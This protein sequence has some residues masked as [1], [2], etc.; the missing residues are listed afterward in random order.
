MRETEL[1][2]FEGDEGGEENPP[3]ESLPEEPPESLLDGF[4]PPITER[5]PI[6]PEHSTCDIQTGDLLVIYVGDDA[7][8]YYGFL[9][10]SAY[11]NKLVGINLHNHSY[12]VR[13]LDDWIEWYDEYREAGD[14]E[15]GE[16]RI[17][18][19]IAPIAQQAGTGTKDQIN[20]I[21][22]AETGKA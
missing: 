21:E 14:F 11:A 20:G 13:A 3:T 15:S 18:S 8:E 6:A 2:A 12:G 5:A 1:T 4:I 19:D 17:Y 16:K 22:D 7:L 9:I 10:L